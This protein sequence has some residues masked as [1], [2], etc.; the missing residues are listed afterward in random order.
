[1]INKYQVLYQNQDDNHAVVKLL[2]LKHTRKCC[3]ELNRR[4]VAWM[5]HYCRIRAT[6]GIGVGKLKN[7]VSWG[8]RQLGSLAMM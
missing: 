8:F 4:F 2:I 7:L 6:I 3:Y 5:K 1:M